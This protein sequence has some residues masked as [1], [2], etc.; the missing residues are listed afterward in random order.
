MS[1]IAAYTA[2]HAVADGLSVRAP[3]HTS[4]EAGYN[5]P[6]VFTRDAWEHVVAWPAGTGRSQDEEGRLWDVLNMMRAAAKSALRNPGEKNTF[7]L[8][9]VPR[10]SSPGVLSKARAPKMVSLNAYAEGW[11]GSGMPCLVVSEN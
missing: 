8:L 9:S 11:D 10:F 6:V 4:M 3:E 1:V 7:R 5:I 2:A